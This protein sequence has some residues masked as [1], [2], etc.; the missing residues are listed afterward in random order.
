MT[1][2]T[3]IKLNDPAKYVSDSLTELARDGARRMIAHALEVEVQDF[4]QAHHIPNS[5]Q[6]FV[7]NG[8]LPARAI[9]TGIGDLT[10]HQPRVRDRAPESDTLTFKSSLVP[11]Y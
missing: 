5:K 3:V 2:D 11:P 6:R 7:R 9:Q 10:V 8:Y 4:L 1:Q